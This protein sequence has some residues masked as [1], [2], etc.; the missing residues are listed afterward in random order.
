M[1]RFAISSLLITVAGTAIVS[2]QTTNVGGSR[3]EYTNVQGG[4]GWNYGYY[5]R[6]ADGDATYS[7]T[8][9]APMSVSG[10][11]FALG[12]NPPWTSIADSVGGHPNGVNSGAEHWIIRRYTVTAADVGGAVDLKWHISKSNPNCGDGV[13]G[14]VYHNGTQID[15]SSIA[16]NDAAGTLK[17]VS[18]PTV[19]IGDT[20]DLMV[21]PNAG[22]DGCDGTN[23]WMDLNRRNTYSGITTTLVANSVTDF[24]QNTNGWTYG[25][26]DITANGL[27]NPGE[28]IGFSPTA[29]TGSKWD[30]NPAA[31]GPWTEIT[32]TGGHPNGTNSGGSEHW[33]SRRYTV[34]PGENGDLLLEWDLGKG[35]A[36]GTGTSAHI[37]YN[38]VEIS[39]TGVRG[40]DT[41]GWTASL[42]LADTNVG[43]T[44]EIALAPTGESVELGINNDRNDGSDGSSFGLRVYMVPEPGST[45]VLLG[46]LAVMGLRRRRA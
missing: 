15:L 12:G 29:W 3:T 24:G 5:N 4:N 28:F 8:E 40:D 37:L 32:P 41:I 14:Y 44:I 2:A 36:G 13:T 10:G 39:S 20:I 45:A 33:V 7:G 42:A 34:Q 43:D 1:N 27:P 38:G 11:G 17:S 22:N 21:S 35:G 23:F 26:Y 31:S 46:A 25:M 18:I 30:I 6:S 9:F 19:S 16:F